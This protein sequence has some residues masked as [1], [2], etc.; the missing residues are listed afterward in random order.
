MQKASQVHAY[1]EDPSAIN[2]KSE[3]KNKKLKLCIQHEI[4]V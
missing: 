4:T 1:P 3:N 2:Q